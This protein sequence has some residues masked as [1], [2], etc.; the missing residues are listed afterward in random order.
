MTVT[1]SQTP[2]HLNLSRSGIFCPFEDWKSISELP[3]VDRGIETS[4]WQHPPGDPSA[5]VEGDGGDAA[6]GE[7]GGAATVH[8]DHISPYRDDSSD[9]SMRDREDVTESL[10]S[11]GLR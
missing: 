1:G 3:T 10:E 4:R 8:A 2:S 5:F 7:V 9:P 6:D 11:S